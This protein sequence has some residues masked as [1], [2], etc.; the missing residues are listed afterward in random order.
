M[1]SKCVSCPAY[2]G[3]MVVV[4]VI[5]LVVVVGKLHSKVLADNLKTVPRRFVHIHILGDW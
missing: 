2:L 3:T 4:D 5:I 1:S